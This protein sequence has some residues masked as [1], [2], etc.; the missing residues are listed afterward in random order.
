MK[1]SLVFALALLAICII[2]SCKKDPA[3]TKV[4][5]GDS[6]GMSVTTYKNSPLVEQ[7]GHDS[8]GYF[9]DLNNDGQDDVQFHSQI[10]GS[11]GVGRNIVTELICHENIA[12]LGDIIN[13]QRFL[14][15]DTVGCSTDDS[16]LYINHTITCNQIDE[17]D[18]IVSTN[19]KFSLYANNDGLS[20]D[21]GNSFISTNIT[22]KNRPYYY[23]I[24]EETVGNIVYHHMH[25]E[26]DDCNAFPMDEETF[27]GFKITKN[28]RSRLGWMKVILHHDHVELLETAIQK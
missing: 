16:I 18:S 3:Q 14:H 15:I 25:D 23:P 4:V 8:W 2:P 21:L 24:G 5:F 27:I 28:D 26:K 13:Q 11:P 20:F 12:L 1:K 7:Y 17:T 19:E 9:I 22:L 10:I 6:K